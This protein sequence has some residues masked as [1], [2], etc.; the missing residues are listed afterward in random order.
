[1]SSVANKPKRPTELPPIRLANGDGGD[2]LLADSDHNDVLLSP[3]PDESAN[4]Q[5]ALVS[6]THK[7][8]AFLYI[9][10]VNPK[11]FVFVS[12]SVRSFVF[13]THFGSRLSRNQMDVVR[14]SLEIYLLDAYVKHNSND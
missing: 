12:S 9:F 8:E 13:C 7:Y 14:V 5:P 11:R 1:M 4:E 10:S 3:L 6:A 2:H